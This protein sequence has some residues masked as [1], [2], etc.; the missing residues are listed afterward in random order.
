[1]NNSIYG[2]TSGQFSPMTPKGHFGSTAPYGNVER[3]FDLTKLSIASGATFVG[4]AT[5]Y[6]V[7]LLTQ[8][9][10]KALLHKGFSVVEAVTQ[11]PTYFGKRNKLGGAVD[12]LNW[13]KDH[14]VNVKAAAV[15]T[16][17]KLEGKF[18]IGEMYHEIAPEFTEENTKQVEEVQKKLAKGGQ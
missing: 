15:M 11:C 4:R 2:M 6:H 5:A 7:Q 17:D 8:L 12:M 1:M 3:S 9:I 16:A 10:E 18:L 13:Y 14:A